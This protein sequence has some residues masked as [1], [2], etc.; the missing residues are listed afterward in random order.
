MWHGRFILNMNNCNFILNASFH[1]QEKKKGK[2][3][4]LICPHKISTNIRHFFHGFSERFLGD[5]DE[6]M[7]F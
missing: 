6:F 7:C 5:Y 2:I 1:E 4:H 3:T